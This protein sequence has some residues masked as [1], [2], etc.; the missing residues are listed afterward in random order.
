MAT[1]SFDTLRT[2]VTDEARWTLIDGDVIDIT[3]YLNE[4]PGGKKVLR[5]VSGKDGTQ[6]FQE[7]GHS[8]FA[9]KNKD[10]MKVGRIQ[11][12]QVPEDMQVKNSLLDGLSSEEEEEE[13]SE[14]EVGVV[15]YE[16]MRAHS[17]QEDCWM[18][19]D[20]LVYDLTEFMNEHPGGPAILL[21]RAGKVASHAFKTVGHSENA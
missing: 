9:K 5:H 12:G 18:E 16:Q 1:I 14:K 11:E 6:V 21:E 20:G 13:T 17:T 2:K 3:K 19:I 15:S 7:V 4:H 10:T 8:N